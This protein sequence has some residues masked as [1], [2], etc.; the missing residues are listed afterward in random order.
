MALNHIN[1][2]ISAKEMLAIIG[3]SGSGKST[4]M[5]IIG[6]LDKPTTGEFLLHDK[7]ISTFNADELAEIRN[8]TIGFVFKSFF[9]LPRL[10]A[11]QNVALPLLYRGVNLQQAKKQANNMLEK[12][13][14]AHL[15]NHKPNQ[16]SGGEQ[17]RVAIARALIGQPDII[18]ADEPTGSLDTK[19]GQEILDL[20]SNLNTI[21][22][23]TVVI[24]THD[25]NISK[26]CQRIVNLKDGKII[27]DESSNPT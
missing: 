23:K 5:N 13:G 11:E 8:K 24:I 1:L 17:Q 6:L 21:D 26:Q 3:V 20:F 12:V 22:K 4:L 15:H 19:T 9:L 2:T 10:T 18:L 7:E 25:P 14:I 16:M 27:S